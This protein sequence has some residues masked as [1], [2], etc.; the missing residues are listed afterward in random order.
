MSGRHQRRDGH[1]MKL[2]ESTNVDTARMMKEGRPMRIDI[3]IKINNLL[4]TLA[5]AFMFII[6]NPAQAEDNA[7]VSELP[8]DMFSTNAALVSS[9]Q[10]YLNT[11]NSNE[12]SAAE[13]LSDAQF[14][15]HEVWF[16][17]MGF[18]ILVLALKAK[19]GSEKNEADRNNK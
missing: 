17:V 7:K 15:I 6:A 3:F 2:S 5:C 18:I 1:G 4:T 11:N 19:D 10:T 13:G 8:L 14:Q 9:E 12:A 16:Y